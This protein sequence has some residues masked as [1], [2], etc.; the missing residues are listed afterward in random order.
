MVL[1]YS[2]LAHLLELIGSNQE[3]L[4]VIS[5]ISVVSITYFY[6]VFRGGFVS[7][8]HAGIA[9]YD[10]KL[11]GREYGMISRWLRYH[12]CGGNFPSSHKYPDGSPIPQGKVPARHHVLVISVFTLACILNY[13]AL[14]N[15]IG[16]KLALMAICL[17][18]VHPVGVQAVAWCSG[19]GY[20]LSLFWIGAML[21][22]VQ[23]SYPLDKN[24]LLIGIPV[25]LAFQ[26][27]GIHAQFIPMMTCVI[28]WFL[29]YKL[30]AVI[31]AVVSAIMLFD[32]IKQ[33]IKLR[34][35]EF[36]K[37][38]MGQSTLLHWRKF[39]V[40]MKTLLYYLGLSIVPRKMGLYHK[41]GFHYSQDLE[42]DDKL[43]W[44][45]L[46]GFIGLIGIFTLC[47]I[48]A[49][50]LGI[51]WFLAFGVI[52]WNWVTIQQFVTERYIFIP[53]LGL[54]I[55]ISYLTQNHF[56]LYSLIFGLYLCRTW[57]HLPT[58]DNELRFY[59]SN[60]WNFP[61]S[62]VALGNLGVTYINAGLEGMAMDT[63]KVAT[64]IN[65]DYDVPWYNLFSTYRTKAVMA[66]QHGRYLEGIE[67]MQQALPL[68]E[69]VL[70]CKVCHFPDMWTKER[71]QL[72]FALANPQLIFQ[73]ELERLTKLSVDLSVMKLQSTT[74]ER[75]A[76]VEQ[77]LQNNL[78]QI[79]S[80]KSFMVQHGIQ[81][82][83]GNNFMSKLLTGGR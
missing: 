2:M 68:M 60:H 70:A 41:W 35:D 22:I 50:R 42:R 4:S 71:N 39:I 27:L 49:V 30:F 16:A 77:S 14:D 80:I 10:G 76:E 8:D 63:W 56:W 40:A 23:W 17:F 65:P 75:L 59:Q 21:N 79:E 53:T 18:I 78:K 44:L 61:D 45:G 24:K 67:H 32:I 46:A 73:E 13:F 69:K 72:K 74:I 7:D 48:V 36:E 54:A 15:I 34:K 9:G 5:I 81:V 51:L 31:G 12:V 64:Q 29:G 28:L 11:Q 62:E 47:P 43:F 19:L 38:K 52:F 37:Q 58:Y 26:F 25:F 33:T 83:N 66:V 6:V 55:I 1:V 82:N 20:P 57:M 3:F